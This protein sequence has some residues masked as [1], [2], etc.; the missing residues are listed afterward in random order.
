M[1]TSTV[2]SIFSTY[3]ADIGSV[4]A[5]NL[6]TIFVIVASLV[7]LGLVMHYVSRWIGRKA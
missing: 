7:G 2:N 3:I 4:L 1:T 5:T 6:P